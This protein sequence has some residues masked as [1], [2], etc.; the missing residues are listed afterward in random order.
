MPTYDDIVQWLA[1]RERFDVWRDDAAEYCQ[2]RRP[3]AR[4]VMTLYLV[5]AGVRHLADPMYRS[6]FA[7]ITLVFHEMG[8]IVFSPFGRTMT[9]L[10]GSVMQLLVPTVAALYLLLVQ[11]DWFGLAVGQAWLAF[12]GWDLATYVSDANKEN[13]P[14]VSLGGVPEH[15][16]STLLTQ[17]HL[18]NSCDT[19]A[20]ATRVAAF[21][22]WALAMALAI[23]LV[24]KMAR[25]TAPA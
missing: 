15:D 5:Y 17:W 24:A 2:G 20:T 7:G 18:L 9:I 23:W 22:C 11:R 13:L 6:W 12:S 3:W 8:H 1:L 25:K 4:G 14:L 19:L 21:T 16:W 10:G